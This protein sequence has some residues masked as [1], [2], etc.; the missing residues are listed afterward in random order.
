VFDDKVRALYEA[1]FDVPSI[2]DHSA[3]TQLI[4][5]AK[6]VVHGGIGMMCE[7]CGTLYDDGDN[8]P[9]I[10]AVRNYR[11]NMEWPAKKTLVPQ[12][13]VDSCKREK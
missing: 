10:K 13:L 9:R 7:A 12:R 2:G 11:E 8:V 3:Q 5:E 6:L 1:G 4:S